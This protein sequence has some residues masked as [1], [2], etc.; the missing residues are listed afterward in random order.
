M[1]PETSFIIPQAVLVSLYRKG[2]FQELGKRI[3]KFSEFKVPII[4]PNMQFSTSEFLTL[5]RSSKKGGVI[6]IVV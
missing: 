2:A 1:R 6:R 3:N 5:W 4:T